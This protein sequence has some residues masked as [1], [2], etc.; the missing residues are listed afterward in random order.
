MDTARNLWS[1]PAHEQFAP[2]VNPADLRRA[3]DYV[4][5]TKQR[6]PAVIAIGMG[7]W[8][9]ILSPCTD[10]DSVTY[11]ATMFYLLQYFLHGAKEHTA[12]FDDRVR[13]VIERYNRWEE[14]HKDESVLLEVMASITIRW[15]KENSKGF[16]VDVEQF[17]NELEQRAA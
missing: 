8:E 9:K 17:V 4:R 2:P 7:L 12:E 16:P 13:N 1:G 14:T 15:Q 3:L 10:I 6:N 5:E 11:R